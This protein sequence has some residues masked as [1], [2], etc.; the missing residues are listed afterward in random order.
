MTLRGIRQL[1]LLLA[2]T[3]GC[4]PRLVAPVV[5]PAAALV[6]AGRLDPAML[7]DDGDRGPL[8]AAIQ[9]SLAWLE[10]Q[11]VD[12]RLVFGPRTVTVSQQ[13]RGLTRLL[14]MLADNPTPQALAE[15]LLAGFDVMKSVGDPDGALLFT[16]YYEPMIEAA[17]Q[18]SAEYPVPVFGVPDDLI[19]VPL[20]PFNPRFRG[21][22]VAGRL[23]D[24]RLVPYWSRG[25][26]EEGRLGARAPVLA[27]ARD[28][29]DVFFMEIQGSGTLRLPDNREMRV[30]YAASNGR[31]YRSIGRLL[32]DEGK[33]PKER[34]SLQTLRAWLA[35]HPEERARVLR[36]NESYVFFRRLDG[37]PLGSLG[38][39][40]TPERSI[41]TDARLFPLGALAFIRTDRPARTSDGRVEWTPW[42]RLVLNQDTGGAIRGPGRVDVFWGRGGEAELAAG[43]MKQPGEL[44]F[45]LPR[46]RPET[47]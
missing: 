8:R 6:P 45:L 7:R 19:E 21:E 27:W 44:Y 46:D 14:A 5:E 47:D 39:P 33:I 1:T 25:E 31:A 9:Q 41:A 43:M 30:G 3:T 26:I 15:R 12:R 18:P 42:H 20:E 2:L 35:A 10:T 24:R 28:P 36:H 23:Q 32:I 29:I 38:V 11:P 22:R 4:A 37:P 16:G 40:V 13:R 17:E 34:V